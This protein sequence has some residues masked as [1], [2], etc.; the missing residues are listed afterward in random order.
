MKVYVGSQNIIKV[1]AV[2]AI[3][4][5][6]GYDIIP[7]NVN[8]NISNQ[9]KTNLETLLGAVNRAQALPLDG[10]R[11][12]LEAG[13]ELVGDVLFLTNYGVLLSDDKVYYAGADQIELPKII[14]D[15][16]FN[17]GLELSDA[18]DK[19][20]HLEDIKHKGGAISYFTSNMVQRIDIFKHLTSLLYGQFLKDQQGGKV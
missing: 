2:K 11:I 1:N 3:L 5:P 7:L 15:A 10:L 12:G 17:E 16:I 19:Y 6:L 4:E 8:S 9:P 20:Y 13:V 18:M 14:K